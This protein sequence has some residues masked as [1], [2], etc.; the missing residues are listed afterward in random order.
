MKWYRVI[1]LLTAAFLFSSCAAFKPSRELEIPPA[2]KATEIRSL[3]SA[4]QS[5]N[6]SLKN[7]KGIGKIKVWRNG[8]IQA[9]Q[10]VA[11]IG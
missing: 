2:E 8:I 9:D 1:I 5:K 3:L 11:W 6:D 10:R 7:F 4:L